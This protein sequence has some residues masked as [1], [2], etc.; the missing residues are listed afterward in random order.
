MILS[1]AIELTFYEGGGVNCIGGNKFLLQADDTAIF[2]DFGQSFS[3][4]KKFFDEFLNPRA[5]AGLGDLFALNFIPP[6]KGIYR[7]D[8]EVPE[9]N[10]WEKLTSH[11][12]YQELEVD[13]VLLSHAHLDHSGYISFIDTRIP[14][15]T[16]LTTATLVKAIQDSARTTFQSETCYIT[17]RECTPENLLKATSTKIPYE[18]RQFVAL[19]A[20]PLSREFEAFWN[21]TPTK[22]ELS[23]CQPQTVPEDTIRLGNVYIKLWPVDHSI[24][25]ACAF[26][27]H[28]SLGWV[29]YTGDYR[30]HGKNGHLT[31]KFVEEASRLKPILLI[32]EGTRAVLD[33]QTDQK[34][35]T[36]DDVADC[37]EKIISQSKGLVITDFGAR[38]VERLLSVLHACIQNERKLVITTR[39]AYLLE[40]LSLVNHSEIPNPLQ[41][42]HLAVYIKARVSPTTWEKGVIE[43]YRFRSVSPQEIHSHQN[44][45]VLCFSYYDLNEL[46]DIE[47]EP[48]GSYIFSSTEAFNEEMEIDA[49]KLLNWIRYFQFELYGHPNRKNSEMITHNQDYILHVGG[50]AGPKDLI[51]TIET[52]RPQYLIPI[53]TESTVFFKKRFGNRPDIRLM[54][55][56]QNQSFIIE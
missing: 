19:N 16:G 40:S 29:I 42:E 45:Y 22:R 33:F 35:L 34:T 10:W 46:I 2:L 50:H 55:P 51:E 31:R 1:K 48:G 39:D 8:L 41:D 6:I 52:I 21:L 53:H 43:K 7:E 18:Q 44:E 17:P 3:L 56:A 26:G 5:G 9:K 27:I 28:T 11:P 37:I 20:H 12:Q 30:F 38:H 13:G 14:I 36:E 47:P 54:V 24:P 4:E 49:E 15:I 23:F 25:G 32:T